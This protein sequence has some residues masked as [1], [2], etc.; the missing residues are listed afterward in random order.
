MLFPEWSFPNISKCSAY[1]LFKYFNFFPI[2][3]FMHFLSVIKLQADKSQREW[4][5]EQEETNKE[6]ICIYA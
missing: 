3:Q 4:R 1:Y 6:F 5:G 2:E